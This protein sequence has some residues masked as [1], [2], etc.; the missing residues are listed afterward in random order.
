MKVI[1][2]N[3]AGELLRQVSCPS[4]L[5]H[6][7]AKEGEFAMK[8]TAN[9]TTQKVEFDGFDSDGQPV[10]PR[11]VNKTQAEIEAAI[12]ADVPVGKRSAR[13][14]NEDWQTILDRLDALESIIAP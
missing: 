7:Q 8:G 1:V 2:Y 14:T 6:S 12:P 5:R 13:I 11:I 3:K 4:N 9:D 10:N